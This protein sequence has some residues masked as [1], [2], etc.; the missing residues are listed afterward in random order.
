MEHLTSTSCLEQY[1]FYS[2]Y[3]KQMYYCHQTWPRLI[4]T[5]NLHIDFLSFIPCFCLLIQWFYYIRPQSLNVS[6][7]CSNWYWELPTNQSIALLTPFFPPLY[8]IFPSPLLIISFLCLTQDIVTNKA[9]VL[10]KE[11]WITE[12]VRL[13][14]IWRQHPCLHKS[15]EYIEYLN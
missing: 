8:P 15:L 14:I 1:H 3:S 6:S 11:A 10:K 5:E 13:C 7:L 12:V 4:S 2:L 9:L